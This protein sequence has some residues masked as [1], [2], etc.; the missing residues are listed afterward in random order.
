MRL[1]VFVYNLYFSSSGADINKVGPGGSS[2]L[3]E[4]TR[5]GSV[6]MVEFLLKEGAQLELTNP[7]YDDITALGVAIEEQHLTL[8]DCLLTVIT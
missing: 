1:L 7:V 2:P 4:A 6:K 3:A 8:V 5:T